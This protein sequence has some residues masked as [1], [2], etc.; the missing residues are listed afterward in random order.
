VE[1]TW[2][3]ILG[4]SDAGAVSGFNSG[5]LGIGGGLGIGTASATLGF[6]GGGGRL[7]SQ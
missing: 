6:S 3:V 2:I 4:L 7:Y 1:F 5:L